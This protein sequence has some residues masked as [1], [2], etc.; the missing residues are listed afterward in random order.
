MSEGVLFSRLLEGF[1]S[2]PCIK[3]VGER[4]TA[5]NY[6]SVSL[7]SVVSKVFEKLVNNRIVDHLEKCG[8]FSGFQYD[9]RC[10][11]S[12]VDLFTVVS[13]RTTKIFS[14]SGAPRTVALD[15]SKAF[16]RV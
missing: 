16:G 10:S 1:I 4:S 5:K 6:R 7:L 12:T 3:N 9:F 8:L 11:R 15:I 2:G 13:D 14:R